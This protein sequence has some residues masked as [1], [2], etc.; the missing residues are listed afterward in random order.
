MAAYI[1]GAVRSIRV[2]EKNII[3]NA[4]C[5]RAWFRSVLK[6]QFNNY[7]GEDCDTLHCDWVSC[8]INAI[9]FGCTGAL[10]AVLSDSV[11]TGL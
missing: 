6:Q 9:Y 10:F 2:A 5:F 11:L 3:D 1:Y 4:I 8:G 7:E